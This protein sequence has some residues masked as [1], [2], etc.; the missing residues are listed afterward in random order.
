M[1]PT[2][3]L[4][5]FE[6]VALSA[7]AAGLISGAGLSCTR[8][9]VRLSP[10]L[11]YGSG[12]AG[13]LAATL[14]LLAAG[15]LP[16]P[17]LPGVSLPDI[18]GAMAV[19]LGG[20]LLTALAIMDR[21]TAWAPDLVTLPLCLLM[22][23]TGEMLAGDPVSGWTVLIG[24]GIW[25]M[26]QLL[27]FAQVAVGAGAVPPPDLMLLIA[28]AV[29]FGATLPLIIYYLLVALTMKGCMASPG[30]RRVFVGAGVAERAGVETGTP[31]NPQEAI[32]FLSIGCPILLIVLALSIGMGI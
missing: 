10:A 26:A 23:I 1:T 16:D 3:S 29:L 28:P 14:G 4:A 13:A 9:G 17:G 11:R 8:S 30:V 24:V 20:A 12:A 5:T 19:V 2:I 27:W 22:A 18:L 21:N 25:G 32:T 15:Q 31:G 6:A 7:L